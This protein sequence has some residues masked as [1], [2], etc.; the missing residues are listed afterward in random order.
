MLQLILTMLFVFAVVGVIVGLAY[1]ID[2]DA[3]HNDR[4]NGW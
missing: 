1:W 2:S 4:A 3:D